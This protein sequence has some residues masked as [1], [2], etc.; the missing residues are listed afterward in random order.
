MSGIEPRLR[1]GGFS[2]LLVRLASAAP[3]TSFAFSYSLPAV[4]S[5]LPY[6]LARIP[7]RDRELVPAIFSPAQPS[8]ELSLSSTERDHLLSAWVA[9]NLFLNPYLDATQSRG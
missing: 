3:A 7:E 9:L 4:L 1:D 5:R 6:E 2:R 8:F